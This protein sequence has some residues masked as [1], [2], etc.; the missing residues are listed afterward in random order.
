M[1]KLFAATLAGVTIVSFAIFASH[2]WWL[3][4]NISAR[5][6][7]VDGLIRETV[8][9][10]GSLFVVAQMLLALC[11]WKYGEHS[12]RSGIKILPGGPVPL[13]LLAVLVVGAEVL[14]LAFVGSKVWA[15]VYMTPPE[16]GSLVVDVQ[17]EQFSFHFRYP[18]PDGKFGAIEPQLIN[19]STGNFFGLDPKNDPAARDDIVSDT[20]AVP[21]NRPVLLTLHSQDVGHAFFVRE[22][23]LQ[24]DF[25]PGIV[26]PIHFTPIQTGKYEIVCTQLCGLGHYN[27]RAFLE[28][29]PQ[30]QF[31]AWLKTNQ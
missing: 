22:L 14:T 24:Q 10:T 19:D 26:I 4:P 31:D 1:G 8:I 21:V 13:V 15:S 28:V 2:S 3:P 5:G 25:V 17:A 30:D 23:R 29:M 27:M 9:A 7:P 16:A 6:G 12:N 18:G 20:L 11:V